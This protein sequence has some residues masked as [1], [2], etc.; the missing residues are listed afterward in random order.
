MRKLKLT[1]IA[2]LF[3]F[4][5]IEAQNWDSI[6]TINTI[7]LFCDPGYITG[8]GGV[9]NI[10]PLMFE[11]DIIPYYMIGFN[12]SW[13]W[14]MG[15]SPRVILR[16]YNSESFPV[17]TPS[18]MPRVLFVR[19]F[20]NE[21]K[22]HDWF[23]YLSWYHHS[24]GQDGLFYNV[25]SSSI[26]TKNGSFSTNWLEAGFF[27]S[28]NK[29]NKRYYMKLYS[30]YCYNQDKELNG[31]YGRLRVYLDLKTE[32]NLVSKTL[33]LFRL[34]YFEKNKDILNN[35]FRFGYIVNDLKNT[36]ALDLKRFTFR[37]T[38]TYKPSF[39]E[40]VTLFAQ[41]YYGQDYYNIYFYRTLKVIRF[42]I[43]AKT[44]VFSR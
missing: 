33:N 42:G 7:N 15:L 37:Y 26:N 32:W 11:A 27:L 24:N 31:I 30:E 22:Q 29:E 21:A 38:L 12:K 34:S 13:R 23:L 18:Y 16:M 39:L 3:S 20:V 8:F 17:R 25:D 10:E 2:L 19:Q 41:Y 44:S 1:F 9:G 40:D 5:S 43:A 6:S 36:D 35:S 4:I 14:G 28:R